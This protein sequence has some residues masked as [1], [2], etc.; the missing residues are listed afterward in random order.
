MVHR[1]VEAPSAYVAVAASAAATLSFQVAL[2]RLVPV[3]A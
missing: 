1:E 3:A 2:A